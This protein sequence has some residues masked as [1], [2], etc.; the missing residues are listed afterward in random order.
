MTE[1]IDTTTQYRVT[2]ESRPGKRAEIVVH[3]RRL[4][5]A[6]DW[7]RAHGVA[8][9]GIVRRTAKGWVPA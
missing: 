1:V 7:W 2:Y 6:L 4:Q 5:S 9:F 3:G 8:V